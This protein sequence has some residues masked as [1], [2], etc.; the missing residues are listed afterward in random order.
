MNDILYKGHFKG[1]D[2]AFAYTVTTQ[3]VNEAI[4]RQGCDPAATR[5]L[6]RSMLSCLLYTQKPRQSDG[7]LSVNLE[8]S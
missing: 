7:V 1:L 4:V 2:I 3:A 6:N 5:H 8:E